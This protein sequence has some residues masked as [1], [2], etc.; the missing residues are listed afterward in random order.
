M[1]VPVLGSI[2]NMRT[3]LKTHEDNVNVYFVF[4]DK[5]NTKEATKTYLL[6][7]QRCNMFPSSL[8]NG[9]VGYPKMDG[10]HD[11]SD[12]SSDKTS[13]MSSF[14]SVAS[15]WHFSSSIT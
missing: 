6:S 11:G 5:V 15:G 14:D 13:S 12:H 1:E 9:R 3:Q 10:L 8:Y 2:W 7:N 4:S